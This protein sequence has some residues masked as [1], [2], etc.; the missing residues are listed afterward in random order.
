[1]GYNVLTVLAALM[2]LGTD[3]VS[4]PTGESETTVSQSHSNAGDTILETSSQSSV[5]FNSTC[6]AWNPAVMNKTEI[7]P[8]INSDAALGTLIDHIKHVP[9][10][11]SKWAPGIL[12]DRCAYEASR[13]SKLDPKDFTAYNLT[14]TDCM[15]DPWTVCI[16]NSVR[17]RRPRFSRL[18]DENNHLQWI[19][20]PTNSSLLRPSV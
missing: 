17:C 6:W 16:H 18:V 12:P 2:S 15:T 10:N 11:S 14:I 5:P 4:S 7:T 3:R 9:Y 8:T 20:C 19:R 13:N 1:M